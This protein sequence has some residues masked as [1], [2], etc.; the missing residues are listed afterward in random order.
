MDNNYKLGKATIR[1]LIELNSVGIVKASVQENLDGFGFMTF[2]KAPKIIKTNDSAIEWFSENEKEFQTSVKNPNGIYHVRAASV[3]TRTLWDKDA[4]PFNH[5][6]IILA[7]N[8]TM[9]EDFALEENDELQKLFEVEKDE[10]DMIDS[11]RFCV[12]LNHVLNGEKLTSQHIID[13]Y[14]YFHGAFAFLIYDLKQ[15]NKVFVVRGN[16]RSL[17]KAEIYANSEH[18]ERIGLVIN[19]SQFE[20]LY[21]ARMLKMFA[22]EMHGLNLAIGVS[23][24]E[25]ESIYEYKIGSYEL[26]K[27]VAEIEE[28]SKPY[29]TVVHNR[30]YSQNNAWNRSHNRMIDI[31]EEIYDLSAVLGLTLRDL[32]M[33]SEIIFGKCLMI[34]EEKELEFF[35]P[36]LDRLQSYN[37]KGRRKAWS[38]FLSDNNIDTLTG[39][40]FSDIP[41][42]YFLASKS[43]IQYRG[44]KAIFPGDKS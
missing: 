10:D 31:Y 2:A 27:P 6:D 38:K 13:A 35:V 7:H 40:K 1:S 33:M 39:Y 42:P 12:V 37:H 17:F 20:L 36:V 18:T 22:K 23:K 30:N 28:T 11:E 9:Q 32:M 19:T 41:F 25:E 34:L 8:G 29:K 24:L 16:T 5:G 44:K 14:E 26:G 21:W 43:T 3:N 4:H 15:S